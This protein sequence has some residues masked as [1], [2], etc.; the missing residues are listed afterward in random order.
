MVSTT[1]HSRR[2]AD[3]IRRTARIALFVGIVAVI[4]VLS[5]SVV[6]QLLAQSI[7]NEVTGLRATLV[8]D[9]RPYRE[10]ELDRLLW[11]T[12]WLL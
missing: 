4:A 3:G 9:V 10:K 12:F 8:D 2:A 11:Q 6:P 1:N 7:S 5:W